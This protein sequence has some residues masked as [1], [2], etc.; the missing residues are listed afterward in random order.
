[1]E[2]CAEHEIQLIHNIVVALR[3]SPEILNAF[4][5]VQRIRREPKLAPVRDVPTRWSSTYY[6]LEFF[7][8][9][10]QAIHALQNNYEL[11]VKSEELAHLGGVAAE[12]CKI[13]GE[14]E[15]VVRNAE[16][17]KYPTLAQ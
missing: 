1:L 8:S 6:M 9:R 14:F 10:W 17:D 5:C 12:V 4:K 13:L 2:E 11:S 15:A 3:G 7:A 16:G